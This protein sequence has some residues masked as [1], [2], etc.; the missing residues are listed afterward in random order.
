MKTGTVKWFNNTKGYGFILCNE[1]SEDLFAHYSVIDMD[2]YRTLKAGQPVE[3]NIKPSDKGLHAIDIRI[4]G[5]VGVTE[6]SDSA[7]SNVA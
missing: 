1:T 2:G 3:F 7:T 6:D 5:D 4:L